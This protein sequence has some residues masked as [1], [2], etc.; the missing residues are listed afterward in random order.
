MTIQRAYGS[1]VLQSE[2]T[3][4]CIAQDDVEDAGPWTI[5]FSPVNVKVVG[6]P[7]ALDPLAQAAGVQPWQR[8][9]SPFC[10]S[11]VSL[12]YGA[13]GTE[14]LVIDYPI[15][16]GILCV[17]A[18][19]V[20]VAG[21]PPPPAV[22]VPSGYYRPIGAAT[23]ARGDRASPRRRWTQTRSAAF[24]PAGSG[25]AYM[26]APMRA[27]GYRVV[28]QGNL[29]GAANVGTQLTVE[30]LALGTG[31]TWTDAYQ[32]SFSFYGGAGVGSNLH[33]DRF[34]PLVDGATCLRL[35]QTAVVP[36]PPDPAVYP[37]ACSIQWLLDL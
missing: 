30:Q 2:N 16:G 27:C 37:L 35:T 21:T 33:R 9:W 18:S 32:R 17:W 24:D 3:P 25:V 13:Q 31:V 29:D 11:A 22:L 20:Q 15:T 34:L 26:P 6:T 19:T 1:W 5:T 14:D 36:V 28:F 4:V 23:L 10:E 8:A 12:K 7:A